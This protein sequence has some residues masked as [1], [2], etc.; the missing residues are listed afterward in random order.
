MAHRGRLNVLTHVLGKPYAAILAAFE[1]GSRPRPRPPPATPATTGSPATSSTTSAPA[2][3]RAST[4]IDGRGADRPRPEPQP[5]EFVNPVVEGMA[6]AAQDQRDQ[7]GPPPQRPTGRRWRSCSTATP[8][9]R[10]RA[11][12]PRRS[13]SPACPATRTGGTIHIIVN[14]QIGFTTDVRRCPLDPLRRRPRQGLRDP[15]RPRQRR[16]PRGLPDRRPAGH[17]LPRRVPQGLPDRPGRLPPLGPQRGRR[18]GLHPAADVRRDRQAPDRAR[19]LGRPPRRRGR[20]RRRRAG[21]RCWQAML[22]RLADDPAHDDRG[23]RHRRRPRT[24]PAGERREVDTAVPPGAPAR[25]PRRDPRAC[26]T[27]FTRRARSWLRQWE[28]RRDILDTPGRQ[29]RLGARRVARLRRD[30]QPTASRSA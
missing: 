28:R 23:R 30:P 8:P 4:A 12:S 13:T 21:P 1:G 20:G 14:N 18:A 6:R 22:D 27:G 19:A 10:A 25:V 7:P 16:R 5:P 29:G 9:S 24:A 17:G 15:D 3:A 2:C 11:S 26:P